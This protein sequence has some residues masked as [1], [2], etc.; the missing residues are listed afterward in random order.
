MRKPLGAGAARVLFRSTGGSSLDYVL[1]PDL[2]RVAL[3]EWDGAR[4]GPD[5]YWARLIVLELA[6]GRAR[7]VAGPDLHPALPQWRDTRHV[8]ALVD[9]GVAVSI[10]I[11]STAAAR[12]IIAGI[13]GDVGAG[14]TGLAADYQRQLRFLEIVGRGA[15]LRQINRI[16]N[17]PTV[18]WALTTST[19]TSPGRRRCRRNARRTE[20]HR[21][22]RSCCFPPG[23]PSTTEVD[24]RVGASRCSRAR[25]RVP[26]LPGRAPAGLRDR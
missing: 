12:K 23:Q 19:V 26:A 24:A 13:G 9:G 25:V 16:R 8:A 10:D 18:C 22:T 15:D 2:R 6:T 1:S 4:P 20:M 17:G 7:E 21:A 11:T 14:A 5:P 3:I